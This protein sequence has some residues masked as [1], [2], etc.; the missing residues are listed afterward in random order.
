M[1]QNAGVIVYI[2][3]NNNVTYYSRNGET[4]ELTSNR[5]LN[6]QEENIKHCTLEY[7]NTCKIYSHKNRMIQSIKNN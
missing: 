4:Y 2:R 7:T 1:N 5:Y 3:S 6:R